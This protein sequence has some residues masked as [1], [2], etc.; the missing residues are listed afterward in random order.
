[1]YD[2]LAIVSKV[3]FEEQL[4]NAVAN[5]SMLTTG[6]GPGMRVSFPGHILT[7]FLKFTEW[8]DKTFNPHRSIKCTWRWWSPPLLFTF[9][10]PLPV[11]GGVTPPRRNVPHRF[12][13]SLASSQHGFSNQTVAGGKDGDIMKIMFGSWGHWWWRKLTRVCKDRQ[14][15]TLNW[16]L[17]YV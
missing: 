8:W 13:A 11:S 6:S 15:P 1:M 9:G 4:A 16:H 3:I 7:F 5:S 17:H 12:C 2:C 10:D 14:D